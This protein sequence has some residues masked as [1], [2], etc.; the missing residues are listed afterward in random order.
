METNNGILN[1][2]LEHCRYE[3]HLSPLTLKAYELDLRGFLL[4]IG[5][6]RP[7]SDVDK[8]LLKAYVKYLFEVPLKES[9]V[10]RKVVSL[11]AF[12]TY[13]ELEGL[14][15][16][17]P[18]EKLR[19]SIR[20]PKRIPE[21][22]SLKDISRL[23]N[24]AKQELEK[25][26]QNPFDKIDLLS[27]TDRK[28][29]KLLQNLV[30]VELLFATGMRVR[31]LCSLCLEN[32]DMT[33]NI[34]KVNG[35]G[36]KERLLPIPNEYVAKLLS[37][38]M[39]LRAGQTDGLKSLFKNR[40]DKPLDT[41]SVRTIISRYVAETELHKKVTP[42]TFRHTIA[43]LLL[44]NG[45]D[46]RFVQTFLGHSSILTTQLYTHASEIAQRN[47]IILNHPRNLI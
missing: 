12:L 20:I 22:M 9:S 32:I 6:E 13:L 4:F 18:F 11:K 46:I 30:I 34:I 14:L 36:S 33:R 2:Y 45:T 5:Q 26:K 15:S 40:L 25:N 31:E 24:F 19:L 7:L 8:E 23:I 27:C 21:V 10:K 38:F 39:K 3:K 28:S 16:A 44:E 29:M 35:K 41:Q 1:S 43:T 37:D 42:H 47:A 17:D